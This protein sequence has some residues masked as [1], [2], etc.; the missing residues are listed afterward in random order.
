MRVSRQ[1]L[2]ELGWFHN[3]FLHSAPFWFTGFPVEAATYRNIDSPKEERYSRKISSV[4]S[5]FPRSTTVSG[6]PR[7]V[8]PCKNEQ[9]E[10]NVK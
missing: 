7:S 10:D 4:T 2:C 8:P 9:P 1:K 5:V 3:T 6:G